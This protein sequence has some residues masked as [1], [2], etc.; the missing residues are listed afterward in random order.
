MAKTW[1]LRIT[2]VRQEKRAGRPFA[3]TVSNYQVFHDGTPVDGLSG[4]F[5]ERQG[6]GDNTKSGVTNHRRIKAGSYPISTHQSPV[7]D[8]KIK[9]KTIGY[10]KGNGVGEQPRPFIGVDETGEREGILIHPGQGYIWSIGCF[11]PG[12]TIKKAADDLKYGES[13][14]MV[15]ALIDDATRFLGAAFP[16]SNNKTIPN[17]RVVIAGEP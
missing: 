2:R 14:E 17:A 3:R 12:K 11:N 9:Y 1:E 8:K 13:K 15:I 16:K 6:P 10:T 5:V 4:S 7:K